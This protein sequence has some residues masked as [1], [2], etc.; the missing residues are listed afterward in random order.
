[1]SRKIIFGSS[2]SSVPPLVCSAEGLAF[3][4][5]HETATGLTMGDTQKEAVCGFI[6][7]LKGNGTTNSSDI[8]T[9][10]TAKGSILHPFAPIDDSTANSSAFGLDLVSATTIGTFN[11]FVSGDFT[12]SGLVG[13]STKYVDLGVNPNGWLQDS[14]G[15]YGYALTTTTGNSRILGASG[16]SAA[17]G[18]Y[19]IFNSSTKTL[20]ARI[21][22]SSNSSADVVAANIGLVG[23]QRSDSAN[24]QNSFNG[25]QTSN[26]AVS[27]VSPTG[28]NM[29]LMAYNLNGSAAGYFDGACGG[30]AVNMPVLT[31]NELA[32]FYEAFSWYQ[33]NIITSGR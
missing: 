22:Q 15:A 13:G 9:L 27:S 14:I 25:V 10:M 23:A 24:M 31:T 16:V 28:N 1:M 17:Q 26:T 21:N 3:I 32:D 5:A 7:R 8:W 12:P 30:T 20:T 29:Y 4:S 6:D 19:I 11:N 33:A 18:H 2:F